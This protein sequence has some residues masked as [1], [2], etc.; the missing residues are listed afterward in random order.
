MAWF[1][2]INDNNKSANTLGTTAFSSWTEKNTGFQSGSTAVAKNVNTVLRQNSIVVKALM[3]SLGVNGDYLSKTSDLQT[4]ITSALTAKITGY[5]STSIPPA[6]ATESSLGSSTKY[7]RED[8]KHKGVSQITINGEIKSGD[9]SSIYAPTTS[10]TAGQVLKS[11]GANAAPS[12]QD[13]VN[14]FHPVGSIYMSV[15]PTDPHELFGGIWEAWGSGRVPVGVNTSDA[16][17]KFAGLTGGSKSVPLLPNNI[18]S[19]TT[20][21]S[22][23]DAYV[24]LRSVAQNENLVVGYSDKISVSKQGTSVTNAAKSA[25]SYAPQQVSYNA[26]HTHTVG[27]ANPA[28]VNNLQPYITCYMWKRKS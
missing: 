18:P 11:N 15:E 23:N 10:G 26:Q 4:S 6:V 27:Q 19:M 21:Q 1:E 22:G 8:H 3:D 5:V 25:Y 16:D 12:W 9:V 24:Q 17:F 14:V 13:L 2:W 7:A 20:G 28:P